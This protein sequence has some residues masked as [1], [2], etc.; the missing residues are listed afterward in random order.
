MMINVLFSEQRA[1]LDDFEHFQAQM[2]TAPRVGE[3]VILRDIRARVVDVE[4]HFSVE[5]RPSVVV[6]VERLD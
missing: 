3:T 1:G 5:R 4:W 6:Y 2:A